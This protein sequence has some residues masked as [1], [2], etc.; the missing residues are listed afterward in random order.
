MFP[1]MTLCPHNV[2]VECETPACEQCG[3][4]P[5]VAEKRKRE[6]MKQKKYKIPFTGYCEVWARSPEEAEKLAD[7]G[8]MF[9]AEY[10]FGEPVSEEESE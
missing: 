6:I 1:E 9:Y 10:D 8:D 5:P 2:G 3:W 4:Y 7:N